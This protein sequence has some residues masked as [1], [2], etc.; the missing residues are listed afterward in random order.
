MTKLIAELAQ[1]Q[2]DDRAHR[3]ATMAA[4]EL[5]RTEGVTTSGIDEFEIT[6]D[7]LDDHM[8]DCIAHLC[9][10]GNAKSCDGMDGAIIVQLGYFT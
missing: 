8:F 1:Q 2:A 7:L 10:T 3:I 5:I 4:E 9:D 6:S